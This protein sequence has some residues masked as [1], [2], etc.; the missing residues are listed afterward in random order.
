MKI[1]NSQA[2]PPPSDDK[3]T[4]QQA[5]V[6]T[7]EGGRRLDNFLLTRVHV[8]RQV[9]YRWVRTGQVRV[10]GSRCKPLD[11]LKPGDEVR[12]PPHHIQAPIAP[13]ERLPQIDIPVL[14]HDAQ[15]MVVNKPP[16]LP[17][18]RGSA[19]GYGLIDV[20]HHQNQEPGLELAHRLDRGTSGCL[21][22]ARDHRVL[23][24]L[25]AQLRKREVEKTYLALVAGQWCHGIRMHSQALKVDRQNDR[26]HKVTAQADGLAAASRFEPL[27]QFAKVTLMQV[28]IETGRTHQIRV[29]A[30]ELRHPIVGDD[31][32][33]E[34]SVNRWAKEQG[35]R[36]LFLHA[37]SLTFVHPVTGR[38]LSIK[39]PLSA[40]WEGWLAKMRKIEAQT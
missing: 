39:A 2:K 37:A 21:I 16:G 12:I 32:Y 11:R 35:M 20:L 36:R 7:D 24:D 40:E 25:H 23:R 14:F 5:I 19:V 27:E 10:N 30:Q 38:I 33:G 13:A 3:V 28:K 1:R 6:G 31:R 15:L 4:V 22:L 18:H 17:V 26:R 8:P 34:Q 29:H 9:V